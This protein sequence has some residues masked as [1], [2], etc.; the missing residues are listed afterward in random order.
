[1]PTTYLKAINEALMET[2]AGDPNVF[3]LGEDV[4]MLGGAFKVTEGLLE[5][6]GAD[7]VIDT[8]ISESL[9]VG[10][11]IGAAIMGM[12][13][14]AEMQ[15]GDFI[16]CAYDQIVNMAATL[17]YRH[18]GRAQVPMVIRIPSGAGIHGGLFHSQNTESF[19]ISTPG[20][21]IVTPATAYDAKGLLKTAIMDNDPVLFFEHKYLYRRIQEELPSEP[22]TVPFG[23]AV[24]RRAGVDMT[25]ITYSAALYPSLTAAEE[26][27]KEDGLNIEVIDLRTLRPLDWETIAQSVKRTNK[28]MIIHEDRKTGGIG[29]EISAKISETLFDFLD[30][31]IVRVASEDTHYAFSPPLE[32]YILPNVNKIKIQA[33]QL[34]AY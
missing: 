15:F 10:A 29:A 30:G 27:Q 8:P 21:K 3:V 17:R 1:M 7:R 16:S 9:I 4:A 5:K 34:A 14:V 32:E 13:P 12:R 2:M 24:I 22:Y 19:F 23:K 33:K 31:P 28:V 18:G 20:L 6:F 11:A 26:L 25:F